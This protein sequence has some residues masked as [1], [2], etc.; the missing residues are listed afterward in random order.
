[1][2]IQNPIVNVSVATTVPRGTGSQWLFALAIGALLTLAPGPALGHAAAA[3]QAAPGGP[4]P[5]AKLVIGGGDEKI[6][7]NSEGT[8]SVVGDSLVFATDKAK[9][10]VKASSILDISSSEDSRQDVTGAAHFAAMA[11]PYGGGRALGLFSHT[12]DVLTV[13][14]TDPDGGL[15]GAVFVLP[16]GHAAPIKQQLVD[17]GAKATVPLATPAPVT[18]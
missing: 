14:F 12:V 15:H 18:K 3:L 1:M 9:V 7:N 5:N 10:E 16:K 4:Q 8:L 6:K 13:Q 17:M 11:I 2:S